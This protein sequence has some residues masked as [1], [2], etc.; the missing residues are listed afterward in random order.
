M[1]QQLLELLG[2]AV[3]AIAGIAVIATGLQQSLGLLLRTEGCSNRWDCCSYEH[4]V[5][6]I[7]G[8]AVT[9]TGLRQVLVLPS[10]TRKCQQ[11]VDL[12]LRTESCSNRWIAVLKRCGRG[13]ILPLI[14]ALVTMTKFY[15]EAVQDVC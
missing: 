10:R 2:R 13:W 6:A 8:I 7:A 11:S 14:T 3:A 5:A 4:R 1:L 12:L 9:S 15:C